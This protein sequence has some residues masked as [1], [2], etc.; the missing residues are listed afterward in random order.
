MVSGGLLVGECFA[1]RLQ[2]QRSHRLVASYLRSDLGSQPAVGVR[3]LGYGYV[4][5]QGVALERTH[6]DVDRTFAHARDGAVDTF[7]DPLLRS[8]FSRSE[9]SLAGGGTCSQ[10][11]ERQG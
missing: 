9:C 8:S 3:A 4:V 5:G 10:G 1:Y 2:D 11:D 7:V 6:C